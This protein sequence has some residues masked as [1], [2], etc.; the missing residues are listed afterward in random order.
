MIYIDVNRKLLLIA[1][2]VVSLFTLD[3][4]A[5]SRV[6]LSLIAIQCCQSSFTKV[7]MHDSYAEGQENATII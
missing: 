4:M 7:L 3:S 6:T 2:I 1:E 5:L